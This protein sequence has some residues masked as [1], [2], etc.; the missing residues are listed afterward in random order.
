MIIDVYPLKINSLNRR[1][2]L[3]LWH[4]LFSI[5]KIV[6]QLYFFL[7]FYIW[8]SLSC[9]RYPSQSPEYTHVVFGVVRVARSLVSIVIFC[10]SLLCWG[11]FVLF[12]L[13][14]VLPVLRFTIA[15][16]ASSNSFQSILAIL[17]KPICAVDRWFSRHIMASTNYCLMKS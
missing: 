16:F 9:I 13:V 14:V 2:L 6:W 3:Q 12:F 8:L 1:T 17:L 10:R 5:I 7:Q 15:H 11:F 4:I